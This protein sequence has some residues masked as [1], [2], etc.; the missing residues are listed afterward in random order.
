MV[1]VVAM[2]VPLAA[3]VLVGMGMV[4]VARFPRRVDVFVVV[5]VVVTVR[6]VVV[7]DMVMRMIVVVIA[8]GSVLVVVDVF[9]SGWLAAP[10]RDRQRHHLHQG[11]REQSDAACQDRPLELRGEQQVQPGVSLPIGKVKQDADQAKQ[12]AEGDRADLLHE[13]AAVVVVMMVCMTHE[14]DLPLAGEVRPG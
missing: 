7:M 8:A 5:M 6:I 2:T 13:I 14:E 10:H 4:V 9:L 1:V 11:Q 3:S 12:T